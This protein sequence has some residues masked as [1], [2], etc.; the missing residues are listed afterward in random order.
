MKEVRK[1]DDS[2]AEEVTGGAPLKEACCELC[3]TAGYTEKY[4]IT[5]KFTDG[6]VMLGYKRLCRKCLDTRLSAYIAAKYP[7]RTLETV[8]MQG[9]Y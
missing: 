1:M 8:R 5:L 7:G 4:F 9:P 2:S 6:S 3:G